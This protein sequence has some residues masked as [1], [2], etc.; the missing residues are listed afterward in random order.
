MK[1]G[2]VFMYNI[3]VKEITRHRCADR[4]KYI[5]G[6]GE[7]IDSWI[8]KKQA[9]PLFH[10]GRMNGNLQKKRSGCSIRH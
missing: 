4:K 9:L 8:K 6:H 10:T 1:N 5:S 2:P 7:K 3:I